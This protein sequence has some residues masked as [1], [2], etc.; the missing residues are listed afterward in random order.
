MKLLSPGQSNAKMRKSGGRGA[1]LFGLSLRPADGSGHNVCVFSTAGCRETCV[2]QFAG[3]SNS[4]GVREA[5]DRKTKWFFS[6]RKAF[7]SQLDADL[8]SAERIAKRKGLTPVVRLN[9]ASD[10]AWE[11]YGVTDRHPRVEF[12]DYTKWTKG[13]LPKDNYSL[14]YSLNEDTPAGYAGRLLD[15]GQN[16]AV[17]FDTIYNPAHGRVDPLPTVYR[18]DGRRYRVI[19]GDIHDIRLPEFDG[20][21]VIV[22]L[23]AKGGRAKAFLGVREGFIRRVIGGV[24]DGVTE[25]DLRKWRRS[26]KIDDSILPP[27]LRWVRRGF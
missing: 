3:R 12:Y 16:V 9:V 20:S 15:D 5:R 10:L 2:L 26:G 8:S 23:R 4:P 11:I 1:L 27:D 14:T 17:V 25:T 24:C 7:L 13:R 18:L 19:D 6:D 21:G 22:G